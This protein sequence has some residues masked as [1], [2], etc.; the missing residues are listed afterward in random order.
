[1]YKFG[2]TVMIIGAFFSAFS[3]FAENNRNKKTI[4]GLVAAASGA[5]LASI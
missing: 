4:I 5:I 3:F 2:V 1:M